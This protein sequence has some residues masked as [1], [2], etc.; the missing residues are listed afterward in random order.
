VLDASTGDVL[1]SQQS[2]PFHDGQFLVWQLRG[3][4][5]IRFTNL[6]NG[7]NAIASGIFFG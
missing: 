3:H 5:Q 2:G 6:A 1:N 4:V 7:L